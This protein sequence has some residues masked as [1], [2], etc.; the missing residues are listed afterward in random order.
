MW[1]A[2]TSGL[3][4]QQTSNDPGGDRWVRLADE[5]TAMFLDHYAATDEKEEAMIARTTAA[6]RIPAIGHDEAMGL[7][8]V[9]SERLLALADHLDEDEWLLRN[10]LC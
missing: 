8:R 6:E 2:I 3:A 4:S 5:A 1:T 9:E 10:R 7:A